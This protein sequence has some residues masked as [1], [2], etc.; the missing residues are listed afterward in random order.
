ME[1]I[2]IF[3][4]IEFVVDISEEIKGDEFG[5][6]FDEVFFVEGLD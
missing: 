5:K 2:D 6:G 1:I 3:D 4:V